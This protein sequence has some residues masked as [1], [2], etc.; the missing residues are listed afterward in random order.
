MAS[1]D[2]IAIA[3]APMIQRNDELRDELNDLKN[4]IAPTIEELRIVKGQLRDALAEKAALE[5]EMLLS[6]A[7][8]AAQKRAWRVSGIPKAIATV[9][10]LCAMPTMFASVLLPVLQPYFPIV[11]WTAGIAMTLVFLTL[12]PTDV[13]ALRV[14]AA[15]GPDSAARLGCLATLGA[16]PACLQCC[17][18]SSPLYSIFP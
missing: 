15:L 3:L 10:M 13:M 12:R 11:F 14:V 6:G 5:Q 16:R 17:L 1:P 18:P 8:K 9:I 7:Q 4:K 2:A